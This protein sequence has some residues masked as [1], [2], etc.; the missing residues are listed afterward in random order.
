MRPLLCVHK[1]KFESVGGFD[2]VHYPITLN[3]V[4]LCLKL[5]SRGWF[6]VYAALAEAY[7]LEGES[8][9]SDE[10]GSAR[11]RRLS[12]LSHFYETWRALIS[13]D[14]WLPSAMMRS[15]EAFGLR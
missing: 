14:P 4:D 8:R 11:P 6:N 5:Y 12:E 3:D 9:G 13:S 2:Q 7:H 10:T 15:T 1:I